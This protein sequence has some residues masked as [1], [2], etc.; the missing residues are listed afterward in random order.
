MCCCVEVCNILFG[1][2]RHSNSY[3]LPLFA[4]DQRH[5]RNTL[6]SA[7]H[8]NI[9][10][11]AR[12]PTTVAMAATSSFSFSLSFAGFLATPVCAAEQTI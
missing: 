8:D 4:T 2:C 11:H 6:H 12:L 10:M 1:V 9:Y 7:Q 3:Q 5:K